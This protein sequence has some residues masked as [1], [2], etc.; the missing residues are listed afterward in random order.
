MKKKCHT[1][2]KRDGGTLDLADSLSLRED[3][4]T[5]LLSKKR[6]NKQIN[7]QGIKN[8]VS[9]LKTCCASK[10]TQVQYSTLCV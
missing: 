9:N 8:I 10:E 4:Q 3:N 7:L 5:P 6:I 2:Y 1:F